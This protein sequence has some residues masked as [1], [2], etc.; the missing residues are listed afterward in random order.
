MVEG[1]SPRVRHEIITQWDLQAVGPHGNG[2][3]FDQWFDAFSLVLQKLEEEDGTV[4]GPSDQTILMNETASEVTNR[5]DVTKSKF[6]ERTFPNE[7]GQGALTGQSS[8]P[9][10]PKPEVAMQDQDR[11]HEITTATEQRT[12]KEIQVEAT[13]LSSNPTHTSTSEEANRVA[14]QAPSSRPLHITTT[15]PSHRHPPT[16]TTRE[17]TKSWSSTDASFDV[18]T[19]LSLLSSNVA[20]SDLHMMIR[21]V[22]SIDAQLRYMG[23]GE[24][25]SPRNATCAQQNQAVSSR[26]LESECARLLEAG[27]GSALIDILSLHPSSELLQFLDCSLLWSLAASV[28]S[29]DASTIDDL[30]DAGALTAL[31]RAMENHTT[32]AKLCWMAG[33]ALKCLVR[34]EKVASRA[35]DEGAL[36][37]LL[38]V[39]R[40]HVP[41]TVPPTPAMSPPS[42]SRHAAS[43]PLRLHHASLLTVAPTLR[44]CLAALSVLALCS[45]NKARAAAIGAFDSGLGIL[46][47]AGLATQYI[48]ESLRHNHGTSP[49]SPSSR[50]SCPLSP[51]SRGNS[52][53]DMDSLMSFLGLAIDCCHAFR[54]LLSNCPSNKMLFWRMGGL[55]IVRE[56]LR[57]ARKLSIRGL[58]F[59][60]FNHEQKLQVQSHTSPNDI[61][62]ASS[63]LLIAGVSIFWNGSANC[64]EVKKAL[65]DDSQSIRLLVACIDDVVAD[66]RASSNQS[67]SDSQSNTSPTHASSS[68][69]SLALL[70]ACMGTLRNLAS[71]PSEPFHQRLFELGAPRAAI[72]ALRTFNQDGGVVQAAAVIVRCMCEENAGANNTG[73]APAPSP[74][75]NADG[76]ATR[77]RSLV[78]LGGAISLLHA[79]VVWK[80]HSDTSVIEECCAAL[81]ALASEAEA[82]SSIPVSSILALADGIESAH[83]HSSTLQRL[84]NN[85]RTAWT[86]GGQQTHHAQPHVQVHAMPSNLIGMS[87]ASTSTSLSASSPDSVSVD[88]NGQPNGRTAG[89]ANSSF[90]CDGISDR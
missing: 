81:T 7:H 21:A 77:T 44:E 84:A 4:A 78:A 64:I 75:T 20:H 41:V 82:P 32:N 49:T 16:P 76:P 23:A 55:K 54:Q 70:A 27:V 22:E 40:T 39:M 61:L 1:T 31:I 47:R 48:V 88:K 46:R 13:P 43:R 80:T 68:S 74:H 52:M 5:K 33:G 37:V 58:P 71:L 8:A 67:S 45:T 73:P 36:E 15:T 51:S 90:S 11:R 19:A 63:D 6:A 66:A 9:S 60:P 28:S 42:K 29:D 79:A 34:N 26:T 57:L 89:Q 35:G 86:T 59:P 85:M 10:R 53:S 56:V 3:G 38:A 83:P 72:D 65:L 87:L 18:D 17:S 25:R 12:L 24:H 69:S 62:R 2:D 14:K 30:I 50:P